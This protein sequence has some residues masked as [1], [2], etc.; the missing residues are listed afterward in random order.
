MGK[1]LKNYIEYIEKKLASDM[2]LEERQKIKEDLLIQ[3]SFFQHERLIHLIV[4]VCFAILTILSMLA[5]LVIDYIMLWLL[6]TLLIVLLIPYIWHY[7]KLE[8]GV[9]C[10]YKSYDRLIK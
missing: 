5:A 1:R 7:Y 9:Q 3:I 2:P 10:L 4:T 6:V 8:N